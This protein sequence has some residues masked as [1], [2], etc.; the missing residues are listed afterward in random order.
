MPILG[1]DTLDSNMVVEAAKGVRML[2]CVT[3]FYQEG[4]DPAFDSGI[5][6]WINANSDAKTNNGG[7]DMVSAVTAMGYDAYNFA[8]E[9]IKAAGSV[10]PTAVLEALPNVTVTGVTGEI[11]LN[12]IGDAKR[13]AAYIKTANTETGA[14]GLRHHCQGPSTE[15]SPQISRG[16]KAAKLGRGE[17]PQTWLRGLFDAVPACK[18]TGGFPCTGLLPYPFC[19]ISC[20]ENLGGRTRP[21]PSATRWSTAF[22]ASLTLPTAMFSWSRVF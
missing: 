13:D 5:K 3:T 1:G 7:N 16:R 19:G 10:D 4:A 17:S 8:L 2:C 21:S 9:A 20:A 18:P 11:A 15:P 6:A 12:D 14:L 22:C